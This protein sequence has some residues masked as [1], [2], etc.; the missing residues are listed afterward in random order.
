M[1]NEATKAA[2]WAKFEQAFSLLREAM[3][4]LQPEPGWM[5]LDDRVVDQFNELLDEY[6]YRLGDSTPDSRPD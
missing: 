1:K 6:G 4:M 3:P 5:S 2:A